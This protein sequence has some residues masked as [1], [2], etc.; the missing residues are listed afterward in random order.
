MSPTSLGL[1]AREK[2]LPTVT[3]ATLFLVLSF[4]VSGCVRGWIYTDTV[5]PYCVDMEETPFS[6]GDAR[7]G[8]KGISIPR[9]P[10]ARVVW[11]SSAIGDAALEQGISTVHYCDR[12]V[13]SVIGGLWSSETIVVYGEAVPIAVA[14]RS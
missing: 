4:T 9:V 2:R 11:S 6:G 14:E 8:L 7:S 3:R 13:F 10:G 1:T 12:K 5:E